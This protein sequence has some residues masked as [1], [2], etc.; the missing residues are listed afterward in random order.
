MRHKRWAGEGVVSGHHVVFHPGGKYVHPQSAGPAGSSLADNTRL[1]FWEARS[2]FNRIAVRAIVHPIPGDY[3]FLLAH[4]V[5]STKFAQALICQPSSG[6]RVCNHGGYSAPTYPDGTE[7]VYASDPQAS[8]ATFDPTNVAQM[9]EATS[10]I[11]FVLLYND[12]SRSGWTYYDDDGSFLL[13]H[14]T[15]PMIVVPER[16][17]QAGDAQRIENGYRL[18]WRACPTNCISDFTRDEYHSYSFLFE[19]FDENVCLPPGV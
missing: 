14:K 1:V 3:S 17:G 10:R 18:V 15:K 4:G 6:S 2:D 19:D 13:K 8:G 7:L 9:T 5:Q 16:G 11:G 12:A